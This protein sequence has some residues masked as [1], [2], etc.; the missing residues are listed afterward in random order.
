MA[1]GIATV[2]V[3]VEDMGRGVEFYGGT[4]GLTV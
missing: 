4:L 1:N 3:P 2:W